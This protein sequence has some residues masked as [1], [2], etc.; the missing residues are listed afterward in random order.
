MPSARLSLHNSCRICFV[1]RGQR[2]DA[3]KIENHEFDAKS[4]RI[5]TMVL[6][7]GISYVFEKIFL[8]SMI[9]RFH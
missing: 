4:W 9:A 2:P 5:G 6:E 8:G 1:I 7:H 3:I